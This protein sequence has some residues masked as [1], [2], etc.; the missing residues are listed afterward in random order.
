MHSSSNGKCIPK[1]WVHSTLILSFVC[2]SRMLL[3]LLLE[4]YFVYGHNITYRRRVR[5][6]YVNASTGIFARYPVHWY[7]TGIE[8]GVVFSSLFTNSFDRYF[9]RC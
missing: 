9:E 6:E 3:L 1:K 5:R 8:T 4:H 2:T 7:E